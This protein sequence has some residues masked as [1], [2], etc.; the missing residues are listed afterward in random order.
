MAVDIRT[1]YRA[2]NPTK[3]IGLSTPEDRRYYIDFSEVRGADLIQELKTKISFFCPDDPTCTLFTGYIGCGKSTELLRLQLELQAERFHVVYFES[4]EDLE[5]ADVD[6]SD[7]FLA[8]ARRL[9]QSLE[10]MTIPLPQRLM[11]LLQGATKV[12]F[13]EVE[14]EQFKVGIPSVAGLPEIKLSTKKEG[15]F[16]LALGIAEVN[17]R[18]KRDPRLREQLNQYLGPRTPQLIEAINTELIQPAIAQ[19]KKQGKAGLVVI[20]DNLDRIIQRNK[21][22]GRPQAE[23][24]FV[25]RGADLSKLACHLVYTMPLALKFSNE[26]GNLTQRFD[27]EPL[28]LPMIPPCYKDGREHE[29]GMALLR[30]MALARALPDATPEDR[31]A[32]LDNIFESQAALDRLCRMS[33]GHPRDLLRFLSKWIEKGLSLPLKGEILEKIIRESRNELRMTIS[34][35]EWELLRQVQQRKKVSDDQ[36]YQTLIRSRWVFEYRN[37]EEW[38][39]EVNPL[40]TE[41]PELS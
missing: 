6:I 34:D 35:A 19:L 3:T 24:L 32:Q 17:A 21:S 23:Y 7:V 16:S 5:M 11:G 18:V 36:G 9:S 30:Q 12:L 28:V 31:L 15:K 29:Q 41:A 10:E 40:L 22:W 38:W 25:D 39:F 37:Q 2:A 4:S 1:F 20:V 8:I 26:Y 14:I 27:A 13:S 33:G